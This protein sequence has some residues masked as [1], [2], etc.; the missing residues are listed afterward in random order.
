M[1]GDHAMIKQQVPILFLRSLGNT[2]YVFN[3]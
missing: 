1:M 2:T 3:A